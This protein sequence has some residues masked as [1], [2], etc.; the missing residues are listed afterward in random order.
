[1]CARGLLGAAQITYPFV[2]S[3]VSVSR[4]FR[5]SSNLILPWVIEY[6]SLLL[7]CKLYVQWCVVK[8]RQ[9]RTCW[10]ICDK[11]SSSDDI[12]AQAKATG[13]V[14]TTF[15]EF[16]SRFITQA[17]R[18]LVTSDISHPCCQAQRHVRSF[19]VSKTDCPALRRR[20]PSTT[21]IL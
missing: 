5:S 2:A 10:I 1:M 3:E 13:Y 9:P 11:P 20:H 4:W 7:Q 15:S 8:H 14:Q 19:Q 21:R 17:R 12:R 18:L 16:Q 6:S